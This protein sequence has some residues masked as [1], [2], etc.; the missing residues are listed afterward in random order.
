MLREPQFILG[1]MKCAG[2]GSVLLV[3]FRDASIDSHKRGEFP[4]QLSD[5]K[6]AR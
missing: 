3:D 5:N 2:S 6:L 4:G 1:E